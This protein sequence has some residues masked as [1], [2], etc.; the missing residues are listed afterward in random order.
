[1]SSAPDITSPT[2]ARL[3]RSTGVQ[4]LIVAIMLVPLGSLA[5]GEVPLT[6]AV[7]DWTWLITGLFTAAAVLGLIRRSGVILRPDEIEIRSVFRTHRIPWSQVRDVGS[8]VRH[9][10]APHLGKVPIK[11]MWLVLEP[12]A[13]AARRIRFNGDRQQD[14]LDRICDYADDRG[15]E[16]RPVQRG[17]AIDEPVDWTFLIPIVGTA[18]GVAIVWAYADQW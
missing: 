12:H 14:V 11:S 2:T 10:R 9:V 6:G 7:R 3:G 16:W 1:M 4:A 13:G 18:L 5:F 8:D 17:D 15:V